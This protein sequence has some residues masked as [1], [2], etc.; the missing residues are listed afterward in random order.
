MIKRS[1]PK[2]NLKYDDQEELTTTSPKKQDAKQDNKSLAVTCS[3][4]VDGLQNQITNRV[5]QNIRMT[6]DQQYLLSRLFYSSQ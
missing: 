4:D 6:I 3:T 5:N 2:S 1:E